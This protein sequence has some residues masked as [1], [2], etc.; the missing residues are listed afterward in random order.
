MTN[1]PAMKRTIPP[2][3]LRSKQELMKAAIFNLDAVKAERCRRSF[4]Y[5]LQEFWSEVSNDEFKSNWHI[6]H[7]FC[8]ELE[9]IAHRV[10]QN[11]PKKYDL[12]INV[13]PGTTKTITCMIMFPVWCWLKWYWMKFITGSYS[14]ALSLESAEYSR[15]L[16]RSEKFRRYFP[17]LQIKQD[18]DT[19]SNFR[20]QKLTPDGQTILGGN[21][22]STSVGGTV[23]GFHA[24]ILLVDDPLNPQQAVSE[25]E[26]KKANRWM[27]HTLSIRKVDKAITPT[28]LIMQRLH[29]NDPSGHLLAKQKTNIRHIS[30]PGEIRNYR[31]EVKPPELAQYYINGLLDPGRMNWQVMKDLEEDLGQYGYAGQIGQRPTPPGGGMFQVDRLV[32]VESLPPPSSIVNTVRYWD[33]AGT[34]DGGAYTVGVKMASLKNGKFLIMDVKRFQKSSEIREAIIKDIAEA[35]GRGT[36]IYIEQEPGSGGKESAES[37]IKNLAGFVVYKDQPTGDKVYRADP[38]SVQVN[39]GNVQLL[40]GDWNRDFI[41]ELRHFPFSTYKDQTD[42]SAG[43]FSK[44]VR[45]KQAGPVL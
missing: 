20:V 2:R 10:A 26:L 17:E 22:F 6:E 33:K 36:T 39:D 1:P 4:Y 41:D 28:I 29:Q 38:F 9:T 13:P 8:P 5:F 15:D 24:H 43:A 30:L 14:G 18:K 32:A 31:D 37:T 34:T 16:V 35:D 21:R 11:L 45:K 40:R 7:V 23:T 3:S 44:L 12:I 19:K 42:A 25:V 27:D